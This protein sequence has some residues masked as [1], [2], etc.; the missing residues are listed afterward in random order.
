VTGPLSREEFLSLMEI[1]A[2]RLERFARELREG[3]WETFDMEESFA[4]DRGGLRQEKA[5]ILIRA[6]RR[7]ANGTGRTV[8]TDGEE[9]APQ[10]AHQFEEGWQPHPEKRG[11]EHERYEATCSECGLTIIDP[12]DVYPVD[13]CPAVKALTPEWLRLMDYPETCTPKQ[14]GETAKTLTEEVANGP[15]Q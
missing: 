3:K 2:K 10:Q 5:T 13:H 4:K 11:D 6:T 12:N 14:S 15:R 7:Q 8:M 1:Q 9:S